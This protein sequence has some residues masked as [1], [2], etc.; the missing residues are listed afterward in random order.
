MV[1]YA[2]EKR[3]E[4]RKRKEEGGWVRVKNQKMVRRWDPVKIHRMESQ[5]IFY[6]VA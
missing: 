1:K 2:E 5:Q 4:A 3:R 6:A